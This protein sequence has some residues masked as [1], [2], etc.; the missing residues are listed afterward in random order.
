MKFLISI[1]L[2]FLQHSLYSQKEG[3][4][5]CFGNVA[6]VNFNTGKPVSNN[7]TN[8]YARYGCAS[9]SS[10]SGN[11]LYYTEG[12]KVWDNTNK[13]LPNSNG[14]FGDAVY[15]VQSSIFLPCPD[16]SHL[17]FIFSLP[18]PGKGNLSYSILNTKLRSGLGDVITTSK[19]KQLPTLS[20]GKITSVKHA[21]RHDYWIIAANANS[22]KLH[23]YL[24]TSKTFDT[25]PIQSNSE[26]KFNA[27][28]QSSYDS[29]LGYLK[30]SPD[31]RWIANVA[32]KDSA[33]IAKFDAATGIVSDVW[34]FKIGKSNTNVGIEFSAKSRYLYIADDNNNLFQFDL[35]KFTKA[36]FLASR[37]TIDCKGTSINNACFQLAP[38]GKIYISQGTEKFLHVIHAPDSSGNQVRYQKEYLSLYSFSS[39]AYGLPDFVQSF[40]QK[41]SFDIV[42]NCKKDTTF[43]KIP[44]SYNLDSA[45][46]D[47]GD[48]THIKNNLSKTTH[49]YKKSGKYNIKLIAIYNKFRDTINEVYNFNFPK[50]DIGNDTTICYGDYITLSVKDDFEKYKWNNGSI[51]KFINVNIPKTY[52]LTATDFDGCILTDSVIV[53]MVI[54][55]PDFIMSD[56]NMCFNVNSFIFKNRSSIINDV[57][58]KSE[59]IISDGSSYTDSLVNKTFQSHGIY[60][61]KLISTTQNGCIDSITKNVFVNSNT[62]LDFKVNLD[63]QCF[64][65]QIFNFINASSNPDSVSYFWR[66]A[67]TFYQSKNISN[68]VFK[69]PER[70]NITLISQSIHNCVDSTSKQII[71]KDS[72]VA[73]FAFNP[74]VCSNTFSSFNFTGYEPISPQVT[75]Y[76]WYFPEAIISNLSN[77]LI[78]LNQIGETKVKLV[79]K[80]SNDC[81][82]SIIKSVKVL[83]TAIAKFEFNDICEDSL[84]KFI[85]TSSNCDSFFWKFGDGNTSNIREPQHKFNISGVTQTFNVTLMALNTEG[86]NDTATNPLTV[87]AKPSSNFNFIISGKIANFEAID[88]SLMNYKWDFGDGL[89]LNTKKSTVNNV[90]KDSV[91]KRY[92]VCLEVTNF[93]GC[94]SQTCKEL[95]VLKN[96]FL[97]FN[98]KDLIIYP[99]PSHGLINLEFSNISNLNSIEFYNSLGQILIVEKIEKPSKIEVNLPEGIYYIKI[100]SGQFTTFK[101]IVIN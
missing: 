69:K 35:L 66:L 5:W 10:A 60:K 86:C 83:P 30:A 62:K 58:L 17:V 101:K 75:S 24:I 4:N 19:N 49:T 41:K 98:N 34:K 8:M 51:N 77:P 1:L 20:M 3:N 27:I 97:S 16:S 38:D 65:T 70:Y 80:S 95:S 76:N 55:K 64:N 42:T 54:L 33:F 100:K 47:F 92:K 84:E 45:F 36:E 25:I 15:S 22:D 63:Q 68:Q 6:L 89:V 91:T 40:F 74:V 2:I 53:K 67:D 26:F 13:L 88:N 82:D 50:M 93:A 78:K 48:G 7:I 61:V 29:M 18:T 43:F 87:N 96:Q 85:N 99:N 39:C 31:G 79:L 14:L 73:D 23:T 72:P 32:Q 57:K 71:V 37:K 94:I 59:W 21:N 28:N 52:Y 11:L 12:T 90:Y 9:I 44:N 81:I 56:S 46:W